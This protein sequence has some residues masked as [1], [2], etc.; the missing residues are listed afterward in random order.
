LKF[1][2]PAPFLADIPTDDR[3]KLTE[4]AVARRLERGAILYLTG[5]PRGRTY[6]LTSGAIKLVA[7]DDRGHEAVLGMALPGDLLGAEAAVDGLSQPTDAIAAMPSTVIGLDTSALTAAMERDGRAA[8]AVARAISRRLRWTYSS[9]LERTGLDAANRLA[10]RL[11]ELAEA[12]GERGEG[13][14]EV[15]LPIA[16]TDLAG[17]AGMCRESACKALGVLKRMGAVDYRGRRLR[18]L[19]PDLLRRGSWP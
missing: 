4:R 10:A 5:D 2:S 11:L 16:Q 8:L 3:M 6:L 18:I 14:R 17:L 9:A 7:R 19:R 12:I 13:A 15:E 1:G